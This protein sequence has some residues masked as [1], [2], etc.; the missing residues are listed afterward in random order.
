ML[1]KI[2]NLEHSYLTFPLPDPGLLLLAGDISDTCQQQ[3]G[4][5]LKGPPGIYQLTGVGLM[6]AGAYPMK[7]KESRGR[8]LPGFLISKIL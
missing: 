7:C 2:P 3:F 6:G 1:K 5:G 4:L 8:N